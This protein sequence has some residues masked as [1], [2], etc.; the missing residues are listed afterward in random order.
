MKFRLPLSIAFGLV[1]LAAA[2]FA[3]TPAGRPQIGRFGFDT[4]G[5]DPTVKPGDDFGTYA[6]GG[7]L[8]T[9]EIPADR[10]SYGMFDKLDDLSRARSRDLLA[11]ASKQPGSKI[12]D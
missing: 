7:W 3:Q 5:M 11:D 4:V 6:N 2:S 9:T 8:R 10:A 1:A 12:G